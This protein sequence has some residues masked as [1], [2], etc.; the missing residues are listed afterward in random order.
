MLESLAETSLAAYKSERFD[1]AK[2]LAGQY[3]AI[4]DLLKEYLTSEQFKFVP[5]VSYYPPSKSNSSDYT[6]SEENNYNASFII[7]L[8]SAT[9][10]AVSYLES[11]EGDL[12]IELKAK[13]EE[14]KIKE[15]DLELREKETDSLKKLF[16]KAIE[17]VSQLPEVQRSK[18]VADWKKN[19]R[20]IDE[21]SRKKTNDKE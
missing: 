13:E 4:Y 6:E 15:K 20:E 8:I 21:N 5:R 1:S 10:L 14:L 11:L 18:A 7:T 12:D 19:H 3:N 17:A 2:N 9:F 16:T